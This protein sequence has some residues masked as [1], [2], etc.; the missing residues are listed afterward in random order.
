[1]SVDNCSDLW[2][3]HSNV[4]TGESAIC[5]VIAGSGITTGRL[6]PR[7]EPFSTD[8]SVWILEEAAR[9]IPRSCPAYDDDSINVKDDEL[10]LG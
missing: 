9:V 2:I 5:D 6:Y 7:R 10:H 8:R 4:T 1:M 3:P